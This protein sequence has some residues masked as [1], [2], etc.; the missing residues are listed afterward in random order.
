[1]FFFLANREPLYAIMEFM[2]YGDLKTYL[3]A[4]RNLLNFRSNDD[5]DISPK[6]LT[7]MAL[8]VARGLSYLS[9]MNYVHRDI[10]CRNCMINADRVVKIGDFGLARKTYEKDY[11]KFNRSGLMPV[12]WMPKESLIDGNFS[13]ASDM[14]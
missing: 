6:R 13:H 9:S 4:R 12:R 3:L 11:Y 7:L 14:W 2:L 1:M 10:A 5:S 8:D